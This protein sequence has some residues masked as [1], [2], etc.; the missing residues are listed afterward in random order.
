MQS[1]SRALGRVVLA[2]LALGLAGLPLS[3]SAQAQSPSPLTSVGHPVDWFFAFKTN[4]KT[5]PSTY[6]AKRPC[7]FG[8]TPTKYARGFSL[9]YGLASSATK[10]FAP[11]DGDIGAGDQDP[12]GATFGEIYNGQL[13]FVIWNDQFYSAP[14]VHGCGEACK[15]PWAHSKGMIAW[16]SAGAGFVMQVST[17]SWPAAGSKAYPRKN[18]GNTLGCIADND[19]LVSQHFFAVKL[20]RAGVAMMLQALA[21]ASIATDPNNPQVVRNGG[22]QRSRTW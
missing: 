6:D 21:N 1:L 10:T 11:A 18:D 14:N 15:K 8:G 19:V 5:E 22:P 2:L 9:H 16:D 3:A 4:T 17:P 12:V 20:D 7:A 13:N